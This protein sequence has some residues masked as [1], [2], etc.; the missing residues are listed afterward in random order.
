FLTTLGREGVAY[1]SKAGNN[2][3]LGKL[4]KLGV[5]AQPADL[6]TAVSCSHAGAVKLLLAAGV[7]KDSTVEREGKR[8]SMVEIARKGMF[9]AVLDALDAWDS[10]AVE[11]KA[12]REG[13][14]GPGAAKIVG[15][16]KVG[17]LV[18]WL[19]PDGS[20][21]VGDDMDRAQPVLW[22]MLEQNG[23]GGFHIEPVPGSLPPGKQ[24][25][26]PM[27]FPVAGEKISYQGKN[28]LVEWTRIDM[29]SDQRLAYLAASQPE[30]YTG[31][32]GE[33]TIQLDACK[34]PPGMPAEEQNQAKGGK[35]IIAADG[36]GSMTMLGETA[37]IHAVRGENNELKL[38]PEKR[39]PF[40]CTGSNDW[41][42]IKMAFAPPAPPITLVFVRTPRSA[43]SFEPI[44]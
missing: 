2:E 22:K 29:D 6:A 44:R 15:K 42:T 39:P 30:K 20:G 35:M 25:F 43:P 13:R 14:P 12:H 16:W 18:F 36:S 9:F 8:M 1:A 24:T 5:T 10:Y 21:F 31:P 34:F 27:S 19:E 38:V 33:W 41:K 28:G 4:L 32:V 37:R 23:A 11:L 7:P 26:N 40:V 17:T 3:L